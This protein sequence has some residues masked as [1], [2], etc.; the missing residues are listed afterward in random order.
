MT[1]NQHS[2]IILTDY[3]F[4]IVAEQ[5]DNLL[6]PDGY[7]LLEFGGNKQKDQVEEIFTNVGLNTNFYKDLQNDWRVVEVR[8]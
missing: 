8:R 2:P 6:I 1:P 3:H 7:L 5:F 4:T